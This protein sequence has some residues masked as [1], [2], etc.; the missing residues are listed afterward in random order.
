MVQLLDVLC[1]TTNKT[2][3]F[4]ICGRGYVSWRFPPIRTYDVPTHVGHG[5]CVQAG[6]QYRIDPHWGLAERLMT[7]T[8]MC[9]PSCH[10]TRTCAREVKDRIEDGARV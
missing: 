2:E 9:V 5:A 8:Q 4:Y 6:G 10:L 1:L 7:R 3:P